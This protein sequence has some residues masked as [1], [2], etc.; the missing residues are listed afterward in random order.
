MRPGQQSATQSISACIVIRYWLSLPQTRLSVASYRIA[1]GSALA[2][3][4]RC[5]R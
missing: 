4:F 2:S 1:L 5:G 3:A